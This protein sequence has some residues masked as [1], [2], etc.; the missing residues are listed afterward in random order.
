V[1]EERWQGLLG[2]KGGQSDVRNDLD[3]SQKKK[4][5][6]RETVSRGKKRE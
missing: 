5:G 1:E 3:T 2:T 6:K 4:K